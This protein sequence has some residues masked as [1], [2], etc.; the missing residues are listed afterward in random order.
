MAFE[1]TVEPRR[2]LYGLYT[3]MKDR[4]SVVYAP[5]LDLARRGVTESLWRAPGE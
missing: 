5:Q 1:R 4:W 2:E 3:E